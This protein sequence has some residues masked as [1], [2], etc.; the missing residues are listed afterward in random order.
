[1]SGNIGEKVYDLQDEYDTG[2]VEFM[3]KA[4][5]YTVDYKGQAIGF[6]VVR[7]KVKNLNMRI[8]VEQGIV[9]SAHNGVPIDYIKSFVQSKG[10]WILNNVKL[11]T[12][13]SQKPSELCDWGNIKILGE[14]HVLRIISYN[15]NNVVVENGFALVYTKTPHDIEKNELLFNKWLKSHAAEVFKKSLER[16]HPIAAQYNIPVPNL[17]IRDMKTRW[18]TCIVSKQKVWLNLKLMH[19]PLGC[20]DYVM[21]HELA[22]FK[23]RNHGKDFYSW[24]NKLMP[25]WKKWKLILKN[26]K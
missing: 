25:G 5:T 10:D 3:S 1:M 2:L 13:K 19:Y 17:H 23:A 20:I 12:E 21:M 24:L 8:S 4:I 11:L 15:K 9:V 14:D 16:V 18:G 26:D 22:H 6:S 7:K